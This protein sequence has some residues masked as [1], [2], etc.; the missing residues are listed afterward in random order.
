MGEG[1]EDQN[2]YLNAVAIGETDLSPRELLD[3]LLAIE[4]D[5]GA[6]APP[7]AA[8]TLDLDL[9]LSGNQVMR[10]AG[11]R[12]AAPAVP[13]TL[14]RARSAGG[15]RARP[16][17]PV[18]GLRV[19]ELLRELLRRR[20]PVKQKERGPDAFARPCVRSAAVVL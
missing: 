6:S 4:H 1:T 11:S 5:S 19:G 12:S 20:E 13:R 7:N 17:D 3:A 8:R 14:L 2:L 9:I 18:T 15:D 10:R 16:V